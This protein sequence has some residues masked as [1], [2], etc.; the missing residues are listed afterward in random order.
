[1]PNHTQKAI[2]A[3][4]AAAEPCGPC[5][6]IV[7]NL[8]DDLMSRLTLIARIMTRLSGTAITRNMLILDAIEG[9]A[10]ECTEQM[11]MLSEMS[12][13]NAAGSAGTL[14]PKC[15][16][17]KHYEPHVGKSG[18]C[19]V[20]PLPEDAA[21]APGSKLFLIVPYC[22]KGC[23]RYVEQAVMASL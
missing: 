9:F 5:K 2:A 23:S 13:P 22:R 8:P 10:A 16:S 18:Y 14:K 17:C 4:L 15:G 3:R 7:L 20:K 21:V 19:T 1:M 6:K 11:S 12:E